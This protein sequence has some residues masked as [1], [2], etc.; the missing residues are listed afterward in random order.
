MLHF[1]PQQRFHRQTRNGWSCVGCSHRK[2]LVVGGFL[3]FAAE[4]V[5]DNS[6]YVAGCFDYLGC[7]GSCNLV[8]GC[9]CGCCS[10]H[11]NGRCWH[12]LLLDCKGCDIRHLNVHGADGRSKRTLHCGNYFHCVGSDFLGSVDSGFWLV[13]VATWYCPDGRFLAFSWLLAAR[14]FH[15]TQE[16]H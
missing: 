2:L 15:R 10:N 12:L 9:S 5:L 11:C 14:V 16:D 3:P 8:G 13:A 1:F 6:G 4:S 7:F